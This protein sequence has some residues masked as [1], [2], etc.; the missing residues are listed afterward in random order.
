MQLGLESDIEVVG[1]E[2]SG[3]EA[4]ALVQWV[5]PGVVLMDVK[6]PGMDGLTATRVMQAITPLSTIVIL[7]LY[8]DAGPILCTS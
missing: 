4:L 5:Q 3:E 6:V 8:D 7:S 1:E 2:A